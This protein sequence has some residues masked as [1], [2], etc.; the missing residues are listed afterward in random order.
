MAARKNEI[1]EFIPL[2]LAM[3]TIQ[4]V[5]QWAVILMLNCQTWRTA[6]ARGLTLG[7]MAA[8]SGRSESTLKRALKALKASKLLKV[9]R[10][11]S[12]NEYHK[13]VPTMGFRDFFKIWDQRV[14]MT[15]GTSQNGPDA[16]VTGTQ[17]SGQIEPSN[18]LITLDKTSM[19][20]HHQW[21]HDFWEAYGYKVDHL[22]AE[23]AFRKHVKDQATF[24]AV[25]TAVKAQRQAGGPLDPE[26]GTFRPRPSTWLNKN[27]WMDEIQHQGGNHDKDRKRRLAV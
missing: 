14:N 27:R 2:D 9:T 12:G 6:R 19:G 18:N 8:I 26:K 4:D 3:L 17:G 16:G 21:W 5:D 7:Q 22:V 20:G 11:A 15:Q 23:K 10:T 25:M 24:Q 1:G 13:A